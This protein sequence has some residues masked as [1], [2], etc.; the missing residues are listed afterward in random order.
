MT[1]AT[2]NIKVRKVDFNVQ[3]INKYYV[4]GN[5]CG[6]HFINALHIVFPEGERFFIRSVKR[7]LK[8]IQEDKTLVA[9]V[10]R[11]IGQ[12]GVHNKEHEKFWDILEK[13]DIDAR[14]Y[15]KFYNNAAYNFIEKNIIKFLGEK[16]GN[17]FALSMTTAL[18][19]FTA[20]LA[21]GLLRKSPFYD[22]PKDVE[23]LLK[24]H[25]AEELEHK[26]VCFDVYEKVGGDYPTRVAGMVMATGML[27]FFIGAGQIYFI[28]TD[29]DAKL[30]KM[31][32][33]F[34]E[35]CV[36][37]GTSE[38][39]K[40]VVKMYFDYYKKDFHPDEHDN[41]A[42]AENFFKEHQSYFEKMGVQA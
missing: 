27:W 15:A 12:E 6:S 35:F 40:S 24:W 14:G 1:I 33:D 11:F 28:A 31:P 16:R 38:S 4:D 20:L 26:A 36:T 32:A 7:Y 9:K 39:I 22:L 25:A 18:E 42:L 8:E 34:L 3:D 10:K 37:L 21:D 17:M 2:E 5:I 41:Y 30:T 19:H 23:M 29:K 13:M